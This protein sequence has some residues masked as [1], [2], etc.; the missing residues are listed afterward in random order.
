ML[1]QQNWCR[2]DTVG[3]DTAK[4]VLTQVHGWFLVQLQTGFYHRKKYK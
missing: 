1:S 3:V 2:V 4:L